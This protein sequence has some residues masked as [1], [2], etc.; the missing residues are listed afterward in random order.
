M[1][2]I[3]WVIAIGSALIAVLRGLFGFSNRIVFGQEFENKLITLNLSRPQWLEEIIS[4]VENMTLA[5]VVLLSLVA[6]CHFSR[7][8][9]TFETVSV[10]VIGGGLLAA[11]YGIVIWPFF[12]LV[13]YFAVL[14]IYT[15]FLAILWVVSGVELL[16]L[17]IRQKV[18]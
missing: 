16:W 5:A 8:G 4:F 14:T 6:L 3:L 7:E 17:K 13:L 2:T 1:T 9:V 18:K 10:G 15:I 12:Y 11:L